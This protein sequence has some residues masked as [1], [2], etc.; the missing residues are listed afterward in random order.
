MTTRCVCVCVCVCIIYIDM[1]ICGF[2]F[3]ICKC[4]LFRFMKSYNFT[5]ANG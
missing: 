5:L 1:N 3:D 4:R 2:V